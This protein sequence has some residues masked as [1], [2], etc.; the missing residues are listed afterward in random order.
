MVS[1]TS[2]AFVILKTSATP[3]APPCPGHT[4]EGAADLDEADRGVAPRCSVEGVER[5]DG[6]VVAGHRHAEDGDAAEP[7][8]P[9]PRVP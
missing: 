1:V 8:E 3:F 7:A 9:E 6:G 4:V 5:G 2:P